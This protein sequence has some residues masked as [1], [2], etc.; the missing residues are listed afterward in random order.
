MLRPYPYLVEEAHAAGTDVHVWVVNEPQD[1][2]F[3]LVSV[4]MP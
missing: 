3:V 4:S 2:D 1:V